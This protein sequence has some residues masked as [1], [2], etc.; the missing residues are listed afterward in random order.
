MLSLAPTVILGA[1]LLFLVQPIVGR[2]LMPWLGGA[3]AVWT[4]CLVFFQLLLLGG[5]AWSFALSRLP[6]RRRTALQAGLV[7]LAALSLALAIPGGGTPLLPARA[8]LV[9]PEGSPVGPLL[10][11]LLRLVG[12]PYLAL[13]TTGPLLQG[14]AATRVPEARVYRLYSASNLGS[15]VALLLYPVLFEPWL[16]LATQAWLWAGG[17]AIWA[18]GMG[19]CLAQTADAPL[20][21]VPAEAGVPPGR[22][23][24]WV[25]LGAAASALLVAVTAQLT[26]EVAPV[27]FLWVL[28]LGLYLLSFVFAFAGE[29]WAPRRPLQAAWLL[30]LP[31]ALW[32]LSYPREIAVPV[33]IIGWSAVVFVG[34]MLAHGEL[35][36]SRPAAGDLSRFYLALSLGGA[37]GGLLLGVGAPALLPIPVDVEVALVGVT[38]ALALSRAR[39][40]PRRELLTLIAAVLLLN[41]AAAG[42]A[43]KWQ[44]GLVFARRGFYGALTV[45]EVAGDREGSAAYLLAHGHTM[46]GV[47]FRASSRREV[48]G[49]YYAP[50]TAVGQALTLHPRRARGEPLSVGVVGLGVGVLAA[51]LER[52]D[53]MRAYEINPDVITIA[54]DPSLFTFLSSARG[55]VEVRL[56]D[57]RVT[58]QQELD[59][60]EAGAFDVLVLDAFSGDSIP[61]HLLT[62]EALRLWVAHLRDRESVI[63]VNISNTAL[64]LAPVVFATAA[65]LDLPARHVFTAAPDPQD[66]GLR[67]CHWV[68]LGPR[69]PAA[70]PRSGALDAGDQGVP[71]ALPPAWTDDRAPLLSA[72]R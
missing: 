37:L 41:L 45:L 35:S 40:A 65:A 2:A 28:P 22:F 14:L 44:Q 71:R 12:L 59:R 30:L 7:A 13:S 67:S 49:S 72:L 68:L 5:Y 31:V 18:V 8:G 43:V 51:Y 66:L 24:R 15:L 36:R 42:R 48:P 52:G 1:L 58:L 11:T 60:G 17:F 20:P 34:A 64:D 29:R 55:T 3:P 61:T 27:P 23:G 32:L 46:H 69:D 33:Q 4:T 53:T 26:T 9:A 16:Q 21:A 47:Q 50:E 56:G 63:A 54:R 6:P 19:L 70:A 62:V 10:L 39:L 57:G 25:A 38:A